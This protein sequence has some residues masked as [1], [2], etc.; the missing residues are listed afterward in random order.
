MSC[1]TLLST[2]SYIAEEAAEELEQ[3]GQTLNL[4]IAGTGG[5]RIRKHSCQVELTVTHLDGRF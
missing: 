5:T 3:H 4:T 1:Y 2:T